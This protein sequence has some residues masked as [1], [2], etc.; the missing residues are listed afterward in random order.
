MH[1]LV[2]V[3]GGFIVLN[4]VVLPHVLGIPSFFGDFVN[5]IVGSNYTYVRN[6]TV[7]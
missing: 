5:D 6:N 7:Y 3:I 4:W 2:W 1:W